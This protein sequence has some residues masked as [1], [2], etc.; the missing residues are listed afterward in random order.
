M[1]LSQNIVLIVLFCCTWSFGHAEEISDK[2]VPAE[3]LS[4]VP[5]PV[6]PQKTAQPVQPGPVTGTG[7]EQ[8]FTGTTHETKNPDGSTLTVTNFRGQIP[9]GNFPGPNPY[10]GFPGWGFPTP[11]G[12]PF[13]YNPYGFNP[14]GPQ[15]RTS[16]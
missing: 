8:G 1:K 14:Y 12:S 16:K 3:P 9:Q 7:P 15:S 11:V 4:V 13:F 5:A 10:G 2:T 6:S